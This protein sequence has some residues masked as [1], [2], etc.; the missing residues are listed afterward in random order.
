MT[1]DGFS[2]CGCLVF[3]LLFIGFLVLGLLVDGVLVSW[4]QSFL[5]DWFQSF[6]ESQFQRFNELIL[7]NNHFMFFDRYLAH[8]QDFQN[9]IRRIVRIDRCPPFPILSKNEI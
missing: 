5:D 6:L 8:I 7:P 9:C 2:I 1:H 3:N 4:F